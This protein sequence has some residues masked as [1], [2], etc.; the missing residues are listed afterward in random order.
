MV[1]FVDFLNFQSAVEAKPRDSPLKV[2]SE[3][4]NEE[5]RIFAGC[6]SEQ[7]VLFENQN[8]PIAE[9]MSDRN[10]G[11]PAT[12]NDQIVDQLCDF[13][14]NSSGS[15]ALRARKASARSVQLTQ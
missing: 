15:V 12:D 5:A 1:G 6:F 9:E 7:F 4:G 11:H 13:V 3:A 2:F 10:P 14:V 8:V